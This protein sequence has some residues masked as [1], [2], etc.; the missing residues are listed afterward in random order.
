MLDALIL[1]CTILVTPNLGDCNE[2]NARVVM[3]APE[4]FAN[5]VTCALHGQALVAE[6]AIGRTLGESDRVKI[7]CRPHRSSLI[8]ARS[9]ELHG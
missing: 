1:V 4:E 2:T 6:T 8:P 3:R 9:G 5:P 7:I